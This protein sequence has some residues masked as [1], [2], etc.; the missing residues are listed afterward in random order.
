M[1]MKKTS[2][3]FL[4]AVICFL[5]LAVLAFC[6]FALPAIGKSMVIEF[7]S[8]RYLEY[9]VLIGYLSAIPFFIA[10]YQALKLLNL[11]DKNT[12]FSEVSVKALKN[13]KYCAIVISILY[14]AGLPFFYALA[15]ADDAPGVMVIGL[16]IVGSPIVVSVFA[17]ILQKLAQKAIDIKS[18]N[19]LTV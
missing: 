11:I 12:A 16:M 2:T 14:A 5:A 17:T 1:F 10:L 7:P 15:Q 4:K 8:I 18:E 9:S 3:L 6:I 13:I 19:D